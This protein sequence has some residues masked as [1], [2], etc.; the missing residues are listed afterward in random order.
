[1]TLDDIRAIERVDR[2]DTR[3]ILAEF[4]EQCRRARQLVAAPAIATARPRVVVMVGM[5]GSAAGADLLAT[6]AAET[7]DVPVLVHRGYELPAAAGRGALVVASS[8]SGE[9]AEVLSAVEVA[10]ARRVSVV[11]ITSGGALAKLAADHGLPRVALPS[12]LMPRMALGYL[13]FPALGALAACEVP[14]AS[15]EDVD[16][17]LQVVTDQAAD[18]GPEVGSDRNEAKRLA[19]AVGDRLPAVYGGPLTASAAY[20][21]KTD[22]EENAKLLA[23]AGAVP[24]MNH[25]E[26]EIWH[27]P[28]AREL[29]ALL[30][31]ED[32][33][34]PEIARRFTLMRDLLGPAAGGVSEAWARGRSRLARLLSLVYLGQWVSYYAAMLRETDPWPV[35]MLT[36]V[37]RRLSEPVRPRERSSP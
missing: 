29:Y 23:V 9:T 7:L 24:E 32:G 2:Y 12:G 6:C 19:L 21:W 14:V 11:T 25:N 1:M 16:E 36:E 33:E 13:V 3:R 31:R 10:L 17:A 18:L 35:P 26:I 22:L 37:K 27:G 28:G 34:P 8:Y 4:P 20:R 15:E 5:G 30:L